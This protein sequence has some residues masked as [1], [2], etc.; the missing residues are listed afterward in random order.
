MM[1]QKNLPTKQKTST[2]AKPKAPTFDAAN[3]SALAAAHCV[4]TAPYQYMKEDAVREAATKGSHDLYQAL[5]PKS[6]L[7]S[8]LSGL[9]VGVSNATHECLSLAA[10]IPPHEIQHR[11]VNLRHAL[12]GAAVV[13]Q[14][15]EALE[16]VR[17]NRPANVN[18]GQ[19]KVESGAQAIV[20]TVVSRKSGQDT[21]APPNNKE[22]AEA[23]KEKVGRKRG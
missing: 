20:G 14:L 6:A 21:E 10:R 13:T 9:I 2:P 5:G 3:R 18:V 12:K 7:E 19:V 17:G 1:K 8:V 11:D 23:P 16:R 15:I 4:L 22:P